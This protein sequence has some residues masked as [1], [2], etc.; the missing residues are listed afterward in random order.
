GLSA[1]ATF[2][3]GSALAL[4][5]AAGTFD[6]ATLIHVGMNIE[7]KATLFA[8]VR[9]VLKSD[10][11]FAVYEAMRPGEAAFPYPMP[12]AATPATS[13]VE[14]PETYR[15]LLEAAGFT[16]EGQADRTALA[17]EFVRKSR[18]DAARGDPTVLNR[19]ALV[20]PHDLVRFK[21][22]AE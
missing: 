10:G 19:Q 12:W 3:Q 22:I 13:F 18:E 15:R 9:R 17:L 6:R 21:N 7:D 16:I 14:P 8:E 1:R 4:P 20:R 2:R 11:L 5:F